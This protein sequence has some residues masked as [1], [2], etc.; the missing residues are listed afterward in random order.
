ME[1]PD[2]P[3]KLN[4]REQKI[5]PLVMAWF[6]E[7]YPHSCAVEIKIKGNKLKEHQALALNEVA[8]G[9]FAY[10]IPDLGRKN[11]FDF[12]VL[13]NA[14]AIVVTCDGRECKAIESDDS[15]FKFKI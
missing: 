7:Y 2:L 12:F 13:Q 8:N 14:K 4:K 11:P 9:S 5:T 6:K 3:K 10:K 1:L 15:W